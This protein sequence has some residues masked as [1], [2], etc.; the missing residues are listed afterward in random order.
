MRGNC[1]LTVRVDDDELFGPSA[2]G[3]LR[4]GE[5]GYPDV[6]AALALAEGGDELA[7]FAF[8]VDY[9]EDV[10]TRRMAVGWGGHLDLDGATVFQ[11]R[12][13]AACTDSS[14]CGGDDDCEDSTSWFIN[15]SPSKDCA[16]VAKNPDGRCDKTNGDGVEGWDA[17][18]V[19]CGTCDATPAPTSWC[20][21]SGS[22]HMAGS[23]H[24]DCDYVMKNPDSRC[25]KKDDHD[26]KAKHA[27][28]ASCDT[29]DLLEDEDEDGRP[30]ACSRSAA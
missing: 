13:N 12:V 4:V 28:H 14:W 27:C 21:D 22:W 30:R 29:C 6:V 25:K 20:Q 26:V 19:S 10:A 15:D 1:S 23:P 18:P 5:A 3:E 11:S 24:K 17:C 16:L 7:S 9:D 2:S 8:D